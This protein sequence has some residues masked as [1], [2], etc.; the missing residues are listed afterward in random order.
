MSRYFSG[1]LIEKPGWPASFTRRRTFHLVKRWRLVPA[2]AL[3]NAIRS[4][5]DEDEGGEEE[6]EET[7]AKAAEK[8]NQAG[9]TFQRYDKILS[10]PS[11]LVDAHLNAKTIAKAYS[12]SGK[13]L[14]GH[15]PKSPRPSPLLSSGHW[16]PESKWGLVARKT[17][18]Y[19]YGI[20][21][22]ESSSSLG[23]SEPI[24]RANGPAIEHIAMVTENPIVYYEVKAWA[25]PAFLFQIH[26]S[27]FH[28]SNVVET[29]S[30]GMVT[31]HIEYI[32][33]VVHADDSSSAVRVINCL[34]LCLRHRYKF[35][36]LTKLS[37]KSCY[38]DSKK[39]TI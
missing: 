38:C 15:R 39:Y 9:R 13:K 4:A 20:N 25:E 31:Y 7:G 30:R 33:N 6:K 29:P 35:V 11:S 37:N 12:K 14:V 17:M 22:I 1:K 28:S 10:T 3:S 24:G 36:R 5:G 18:Y 19:V 2:L 8:R 26:N 16:S 32:E 23:P 27:T 21:G 34:L